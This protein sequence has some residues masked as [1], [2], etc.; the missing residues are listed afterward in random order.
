M[1]FSVDWP[2]SFGEE[3]F[4]KMVDADDDDGHRSICI[5]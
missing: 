4:L 3:D 2:N 5:L 1:K